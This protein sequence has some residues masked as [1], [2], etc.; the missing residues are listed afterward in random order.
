MLPTT[1]KKKKEKKVQRHENK[2]TFQ[3]IQYLSKNTQ[4]PRLPDAI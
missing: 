1:V 3:L 4:K 2:L